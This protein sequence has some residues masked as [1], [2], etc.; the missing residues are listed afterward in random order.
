V[1]KLETFLHTLFLLGQ[2]ASKSVTSKYF[3]HTSK[4]EGGQRGA[5]KE[6]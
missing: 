1:N 6:Q 2:L 4:T 5:F 3:C